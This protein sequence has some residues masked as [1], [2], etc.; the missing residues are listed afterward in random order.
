MGVCVW[1]DVCGGGECVCVSP[2]LPVPPVCALQ[3][4]T[5]PAPAPFLHALAPHAGSGRGCRA[6]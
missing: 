3:K 1:G 2:Q 4:P 6:W 5:R